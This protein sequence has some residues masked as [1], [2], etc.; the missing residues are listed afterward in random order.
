ME[1]SNAFCLVRI[2]LKR[3]SFILIEAAE[4][5]DVSPFYRFSLPFFISFFRLE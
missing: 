4:A 3:K 2:L 5:F 1:T